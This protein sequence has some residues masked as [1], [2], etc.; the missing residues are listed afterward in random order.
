MDRHLEH[1][2]LRAELA[3]LAAERVDLWADAHA[4]AQIETDLSSLLHRWQRAAHESMTVDVTCIDGYMIRGRCREVLE[5]F[6]V[7]H[8]DSGTYAIAC[9]HLVAIRGLPPALAA[10]N[11]DLPSPRH[12]LN[13]DTAAVDIALL[14]AQ[15]LRGRI[16]S[17]TRDH[18]NVRCPEGDT[19]TVPMSAII[20]IRWHQ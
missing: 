5:R 9:A 15:H 16:T 8:S 19:I 17:V 1:A 11:P 20:R 12:L 4:L 7:L 3:A 10:E 14:G 18:I 2:L 13:A 6:I